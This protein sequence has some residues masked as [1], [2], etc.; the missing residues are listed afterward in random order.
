MSSLAALSMLQQTT[1]INVKPLWLL[2]RCPSLLTLRSRSNVCHRGAGVVVST[3]AGI[4]M[5]GPTTMMTV[6]VSFI[7]TC[8]DGPA[9]SLQGSPTVS[10]VTAALCASLPF[11]PLLPASMYFFALSQAP[12]PLFKNKAINMAV[13]EETTRYDVMAL[14]PRRSSPVDSPM[15]WNIL[16][17]RTGAA[18]TR[19]PGL[20]ICLIAASDTMPTQTP[21]NGCLSPVAMPGTS[22][23]CRRTSNTTFCAV[24]PTA[25]IAMPAKRNTVAPP[26]MPP[27]KVSGATI[28]T[29]I[30][31][32][33]PSSMISMKALNKRKHASPAEPTAYPLV[34]ALV[35]L[36][37]A[38]NRSIVSLA[39]AGHSG[40]ISTMPAALS[41]IGPNTSMAKT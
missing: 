27:T 23:N 38:S 34:K 4:V 24:S 36:P 11:P 37:A 25:S 28:S 21:Y 41:A 8:R 31:L 35:V 22:L 30:F 16:P 13:I 17:T 32:P 26:M 40:L 7:K 33:L 10:P 19:K 1:P 12:P 20:I 3:T 39:E 15:A 5:I 6:A 14:A 29:T 9:V 18:S 2:R